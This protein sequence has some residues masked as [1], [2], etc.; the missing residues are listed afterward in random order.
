MSRSSIGTD[1]NCSRSRSKSAPTSRHKAGSGS[2]ISRPFE[3]ARR[4]RRREL[5]RALNDRV[6]TLVRRDPDTTPEAP[7]RRSR[8]RTYEEDDE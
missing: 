7:P 4:A 8:L 5:R 6:P 2:R 1:R 3:A